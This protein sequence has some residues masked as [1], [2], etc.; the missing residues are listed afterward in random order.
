MRSNAGLLKTLMLVACGVATPLTAAPL[1][2]FGIFVFS[3]LCTGP[4]DPAGA[5]I[6]LERS[7]TGDVAVYTRTEGPISAPLLAYGPDVKVDDRTGRIRMRFVDPEF[8]SDGV[9]VLEGTVTDQMM[10]ISGQK[11][12]RVTVF[13]SKLSKC[14]P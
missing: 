13:A 12:P 11:L 10:E 3:S 6:I 5:E 8:G 2:R 1:P 14:R 9:Y 7:A 4:A